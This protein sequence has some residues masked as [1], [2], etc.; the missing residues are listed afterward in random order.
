MSNNNQKKFFKL[1]HPTQERSLTISWLHFTGGRAH[2]FEDSHGGKYPQNDAAF[3]LGVGSGYSL[4][5]KDSR[6]SKMHGKLILYLTQL[7]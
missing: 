2:S 7:L 1:G 5:L 6:V 4:I 3:V